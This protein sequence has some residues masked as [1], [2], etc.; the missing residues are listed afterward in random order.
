MFVVRHGL[1]PGPSPGLTGGSGAVVRPTRIE[2]YRHRQ[3]VRLQ[4]LCIGQGYRVRPK[5][6]QTV[7]AAGDHRGT[8]E[9]IEH[10]QTR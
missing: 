1:Y 8:F 9:K 5:R 6:P 10:A 7:G 4:S 3:G 2:P